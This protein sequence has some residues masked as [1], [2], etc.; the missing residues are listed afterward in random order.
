[1]EFIEDGGYHKPDLWLNLGFS[2]F[3][4]KQL[5][6]PLYWHQTNHE[7]F[8][9]TMH[10]CEPINPNEP[11]SHVSFYEADAYARW[12]GARLPTEAE[13]EVAAQ[14]LHENQ[15]TKH[16][17]LSSGAFRPLPAAPQKT[18]LLQM[19][20]DLWEWT[21]SAYLPYPGFKP[22]TGPEGEYNGKFMSNQMVLRGGSCATPRGHIR[23]SYRN[24]FPPMTRWQFS[25]IRLAR[26][27]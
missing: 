26:G 22:L 9:F 24:F 2:T 7:W 8:I 14:S 20:G 4:K 21:S 12:R 27:G 5:T 11:V 6:T 19:F 18:D 15:V 23:T 25:G 13:W 10:G 3:K 1:M 16:N 17:D